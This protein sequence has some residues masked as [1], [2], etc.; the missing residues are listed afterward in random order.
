MKIIFITKHKIYLDVLKGGEIASKA[1][2][3]ALAEICG[4]KNIELLEIKEKENLF[5]KYIQYL[6]KRDGYDK[7]EERRL[8]K[9][10]NDKSADIVFFDGSW[11]GG[12]IYKLNVNS[13]KIVFLHNV[14]KKYSLDRMKRNMLTAIKYRSVAFN[15]KQ[16]ITKA[17]YVFVLNQ[18]DNQLIKK[19]YQRECDLFLPI[20][21]KD[22]YCPKVQ[23]IE[24]YG[25]KSLLFVGS[26][27]QPNVNGIIWFIQEV[28]PKVECKLIIIGKN[29]EKIKY[30]ENENIIV[31][32]TVKNTAEYYNCADAVVM[33]IF[34]GGGMKV[35]TAEAM[36]YGKK[37]L[38]TQE[39]L[40]GY[41]DEKVEGI[42]ECNT[43]EDYVDAIKNLDNQKFKQNIRRYFLDNFS[44]EINKKRLGDFFHECIS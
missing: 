20:A 40:T 13:K 10:I 23:E 24:I 41:C 5:E 7:A 11:F 33:P 36:M 16:I 27:F 30:L 31:A 39:A 21:L 17:D 8:S 9:Y 12:L 18:R 1:N 22:T 14:E 28:L 32:G 43:V 6:F 4:E 29:M 3:D 19:Y 37:I 44:Y 2:Y 26:Y 25:K 38:G 35:K 34:S 42:C 15:E